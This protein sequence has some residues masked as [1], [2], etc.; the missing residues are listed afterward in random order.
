MLMLLA[1]D[2]LVGCLVTIK[3]ED[4]MAEGVERPTRNQEVVA[5]GSSPTLMTWLEFY[6]FF[7][8]SPEPCL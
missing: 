2:G 3:E 8:S 7:K 4:C 5:I 1:G 6:F